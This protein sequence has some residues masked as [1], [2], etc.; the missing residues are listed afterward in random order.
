MSDIDGEHGGCTFKV[1]HPI[2]S[3]PLL[4][5]V[6][7]PSRTNDRSFRRHCVSAI[8]ACYIRRVR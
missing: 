1:P 7:R 3:Y 5:P 4:T 8:V 6:V 2:L